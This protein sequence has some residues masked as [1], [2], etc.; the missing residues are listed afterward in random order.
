MPAALRRHEPPSPQIPDISVQKCSVQISVSA[1]L[2]TPQA[3]LDR[4]ADEGFEEG[5][6]GGS[7]ERFRGGFR[8]GIPRRNSE[9]GFR[10]GFRGGIPRGIPKGDSDGDSERDSRRDSRS[11]SEKPIEEPNTPLGESRLERGTIRVAGAATRFDSARVRYSSEL[12]PRQWTS[13]SIS[14]SVSRSSLTG[15]ARR[16]RRRVVDAFRNPPPEATTYRFKTSL[17]RRQPSPE[18]P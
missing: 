10:G 17:T 2:D 7:E 4:Y 6:R 18:R 15:G 13:I 11:P 1:E 9:E 5:F 12:T 16:T 3:S 14:T 8:G